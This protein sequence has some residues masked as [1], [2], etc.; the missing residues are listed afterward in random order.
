MNISENCQNQLFIAMRIVEFVQRKVIS[1]L[2]SQKKSRREK[3]FSIVIV[4]NTNT[5]YNMDNSI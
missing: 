1:E 5:F 2:T 3:F 4:I